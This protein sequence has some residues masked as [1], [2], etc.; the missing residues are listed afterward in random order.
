M[1]TYFCTSATIGYSVYSVWVLSDVLDAD[2]DWTQ[3]QIQNIC[4]RPRSQSRP[5]SD[6]RSD[7]EIDPDPNLDPDLTSDQIMKFISWF[8]HINSNNR[9]VMTWIIGHSMLFMMDFVCLFIVCGCTSDCMEALSVYH[10][11]LRHLLATSSDPYTLNR[12]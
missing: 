4:S 6:L 9:R 2:P 11:N 10:R 7:H 12:C 3:I 5:R 1:A 8:L